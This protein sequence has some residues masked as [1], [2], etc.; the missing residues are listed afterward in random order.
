MRRRRII[1]LAISLVLVASVA[2]YAMLRR[3]VVTVFISDPCGACSSDAP[4]KPCDIVLRMEDRLEQYIQQAGLTGKVD[5]TVHNTYFEPGR[6]LY[7]AELER[8]GLSRKGLVQPVLLVGDSLLNGWDEVEAGTV[9]ALQRERYG[10]LAP[11]FSREAPVEAKSFVVDKSS[12]D[13]VYFGMDGCAECGKTE[14]LLQSLTPEGQILKYNLSDGDM[15]LFEAYCEAYG[16]D[17]TAAVVPAVFTEGVA[18]QGYD[19][20]EAWKESI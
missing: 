4:C 12:P 1:A 20:I 15:P 8:R 11:L 5:F 13:I 3:T 16:L 14:S 10:I 19:S 7:P 9:Q 17:V 6:S 2:A 18:L